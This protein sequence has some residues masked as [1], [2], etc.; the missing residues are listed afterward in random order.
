MVIRVV[1]GCEMGTRYRI[2]RWDAFAFHLYYV[3]KE[4]AL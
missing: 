3:C 1:L 4:A 2:Q